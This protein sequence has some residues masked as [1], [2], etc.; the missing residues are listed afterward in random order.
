[1]KKVDGKSTFFIKKLT[2]NQKC[3]IFYID[4]SEKDETMRL[5]NKC[6]YTFQIEWIS[7]Q[8]LDYT[9]ITTY[10]KTPKQILGIISRSK[11]DIESFVV[12]YQNRYINLTY[13]DDYIYLELD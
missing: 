4:T 7:K 5:D 12:D 10:R 2:V 6:R 8:S 1:M 3:V 9:Y 11:R 13:D